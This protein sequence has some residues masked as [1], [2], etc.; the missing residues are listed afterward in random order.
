MGSSGKTAWL[1]RGWLIAG[2]LDILWAT[3]ISAWRGVAPSRVLQF[4]AS[5]ALGPASFQGWLATAHS[6]IAAKL[7]KKLRAELGL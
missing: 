4:V 3:G 1:L 7:T 5:G 2:T 6:L